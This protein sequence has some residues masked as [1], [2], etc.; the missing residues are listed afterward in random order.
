[1]IRCF[2]KFPFQVAAPEFGSGNEAG[3][4]FGDIENNGMA[5]ERDSTL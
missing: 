3:C 2:R 4:D 5:A 1:M